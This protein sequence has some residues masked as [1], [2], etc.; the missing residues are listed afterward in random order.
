MF[1]SDC[2]LFCVINC[3]SVGTDDGE[4]DIDKS[5]VGGKLERQMAGKKLSAKTIKAVLELICDEAV[6]QTL[7]VTNIFNNII[8]SN[9]FSIIA[10]VHMNSVVKLF[11][12]LKP[13][14]YDYVLI[15][16]VEISSQLP[17]KFNRSIVI[18]QQK[19][20]IFLLK[21]VMLKYF[22]SIFCTL[23]N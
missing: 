22:N 17:L 14:C 6:S 4:E 9:C 1:N 19:L 13:F 5:S 8:L 3:I 20:H 15:T 2:K 11:L 7:T 12:L 18:I 16:H 23:R 21:S 10:Q